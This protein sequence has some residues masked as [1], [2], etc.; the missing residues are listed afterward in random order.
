M[1]LALEIGAVWIAVAVLEAL[2][3]GRFL[4]AG[5]GCDGLR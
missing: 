4:R 3:V 5:R 1:K 2:F